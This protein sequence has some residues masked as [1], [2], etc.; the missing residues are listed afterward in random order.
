MLPL[1]LFLGFRTSLGEVGLWWGLVGALRAVALLLLLRIR[2]R[3]GRELRRL[4]LDDGV[5]AGT[6]RL[7]AAKFHFALAWGRINGSE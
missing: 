6:G 2:Q 4:L 1:R 3:F 5:P 7:S